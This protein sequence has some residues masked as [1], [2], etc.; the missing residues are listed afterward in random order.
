[1]IAKAQALGIGIDMMIP[2]PQSSS[3]GG[4]TSGKRDIFRALRNW[5]IQYCGANGI[6]VIDWWSA[7]AGSTPM[8]NPT[9]TDIN[10]SSGV[11]F[12]NVH[13]GSAGAMIGGKALAAYLRTFV[14]R[15][16]RLT[17]NTADGNMLTNGVFSGSGGTNSTTGGSG[18]VAAS[19]TVSSTAGTP[20]VAASVVARTVAND[21]DAIGNNQRMAITFGAA[22]DTVRLSQATIHS[23]LTNGDTFRVAVSVKLSA[24]G[25]QFVKGLYLYVLSQTA[26]TG[27]LQMYDL[28]YNSSAGA[29]F[30]D[31]CDVV[32]EVPAYV[33]TPQAVHGSPSNVICYL[34]VIG[35]AA[36]VATV[37]VGRFTAVKD[38]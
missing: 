1:V 27:N 30:P 24:T 31:G 33:R 17:A 3:R 38:Q 28:A 32:L 16:E 12:D 6:G 4:W 21:G 26:T 11:L 15:A 25:C 19:W 37:D 20:G 9:D 23:Q 5:L 13:P 29:A 34:E 22:N 10:P 35:A 8:V 36:G 14:P 7:T 2:P 18:T